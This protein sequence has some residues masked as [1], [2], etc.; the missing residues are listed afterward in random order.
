MVS[1]SFIL[2]ST[3]DAPTGLNHWDYAFAQSLYEIRA[4]QSRAAQKPELAHRI[5][6]KLAQ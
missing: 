2:G 4:R 5:A 3:S 1:L 6:A